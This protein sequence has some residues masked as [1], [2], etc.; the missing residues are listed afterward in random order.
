MSCCADSDTPQRLEESPVAVLTSRRAAFWGPA[1]V[2]P[3]LILS[4]AR[5][6]YLVAVETAQLLASWEAVPRRLH[7][8][9]ARRASTV[10]RDVGSSRLR[11]NTTPGLVEA[12]RGGTVTQARPLDGRPRRAHRRGDRQQGQEHHLQPDQPP[13]DGDG[14]T[15]RLRRQHRGAH[16]GPAGGRAVRAGAVELPVQ[17]LDRLAPRRG[18]HRALSRAPRRARRRAGVLPGQAE[19]ARASAGDD[20]GQRRRPAARHGVGRPAGGARRHPADHA[21]GSRSGRHPVV[22]PGRPAVVCSGGAAAGRPA[23]RGQPLRGPGRARHARCGRG[24]PQGQPRRRG[25][26]V[27]GPGP[28][29]H[30]DHRPVR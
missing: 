30:R 16:A 19:P 22:P 2:A 8:S 6:A 27:P 20:R 10:R 25:R 26:R 29:A 7:W 4:T 9:P 11:A 15:E 5:P 17:R 18:G 23:Q 1:G 13:V 14:P 3:A 24:G 28:P 21:C 12:S